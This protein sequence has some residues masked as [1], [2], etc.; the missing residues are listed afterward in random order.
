[1]DV[2]K[3]HNRSISC[4]GMISF[5]SWLKKFAYGLAFIAIAVMQ[6]LV[7]LSCTPITATDASLKTEPGAPIET[8][9]AETLMQQGNK[10]FSDGK[11]EPA[12]Q[13]W[14]DAAEQFAKKGYH[15]RQC[16]ALVQLS[17]GYQSM[18]LTGKAT[19]VAQSAVAVARDIDDSALEARAM[20]RL[21][22]VYLSV[23]QI[24]L[25][26]QYLQKSLKI[27]KKQQDAEL[28][29]SIYNNLGNLF[30]SQEEFRDASLAYQQSLELIRE[31]GN[32]TLLVTT[33]VNA[34]MTEVNNQ[35]YA[36]AVTMLEEAE[37]I[38]PQ[39]K[40]SHFKTFAI[41]NIGKTYQALAD[42][43]TDLAI[44]FTFRAAEN[45]Q[46]AAKL[47]REMSDQYLTS[48]ALGYLGKLYEDHRR[49]EEAL[50]LTRQAIFAAQQVQADTSLYR[51]YWQVGRIL[52]QL[53]KMDDAIEAYRQS[54]GS[55]QS[56]RR[57]WVSCYGPDRISYREIVGSV[58]FD[59]VDLLLQRAASSSIEQETESLLY[60]A[61]E[62]V[63]LSRLFELRNYYQDD[64]IGAS[65]HQ[66]TSLDR[67]SKTAVVIYPILLEDRIELL[68]SLPGGLKHYRTEVALDEVVKSVRHF[69]RM[70]EKRTT[71]EFIP[72]AQV[73]YNWL[74]RPLLSDLTSTDIDT[75]VFVPD[76]S[77]R[78]IPMAAL[79]DGQ[80]FLIQK[81]AVAVT[82]GLSLTDPRPL[83]RE[84]MHFLAFGLTQ[85]VHG[86][87]ALPYVSY[88]LAAIQSM[89]TGEVWLNDRFLT[90][91]I[92]SAMSDETFTALHIASHAQFGHGKEDT[93]L[94]AFDDK[95]TLDQ[96][97]QSV[98]LLQ[99][100][101]EPL[102]M[103]TF[104]ACE[105]AAGD[106]MAALGLAGV[107]V[108][109]GARSALATLWHINDRASSLLLEEFYKQLR[110][111]SASRARAL[112]LAQ[113]KLLDDYRFQHPGYWSPFLLINNWL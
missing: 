68:A 5:D 52:K 28:Q 6:G 112:Q 54:I 102:E 92:S 57:D 107:A 58:C 42:A 65:R 40:N 66:D 108:K 76:G 106:D 3:S 37:Q 67:V 80:E 27:A 29:A 11:F 81:Y 21:G 43:G 46:L 4:G 24:Q 41:I 38:V 18:G 51:W 90:T 25:A 59:L 53:D 45:F 33:L 71:R 61:R 60:E 9:R 44:P 77:L 31:M 1:M 78:T 83:D 91:N 105:T 95:L 79:H 64:C 113:I 103:L 94:L 73:L 75:L 93:F 88:E 55:L 62:V 69:R 74:I 34:A 2:K 110:G 12:V 16:E 49:Y 97:E 86:Y 56:I 50:T 109:A 26:L 70:L 84:K 47:S 30:A 22:D 96:L 72:Q 35:T 17:H 85:P 99:F 89:Y 13:S 82:P 101:D 20:A 111:T 48:Y 100:R 15:R 98:G 14:R 87:P 104:S 63:E 36:Q 32:A 8:S 7:F 19:E 23:E 39:L 10:Y